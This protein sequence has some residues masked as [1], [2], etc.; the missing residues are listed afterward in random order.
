MS[1]GKAKFDPQKHH[2]RSI[3]LR[4]YDYSSGGA[5]YITIVTQGRECLFGEI[6]AREIHL[7]EYGEVIQK[8][9]NEIPIHFP[10]VELGAFIIMPNH[11]H[12]I[13]WIHE[14]QA[15][16]YAVQQNKTI[17]GKNGTARDS[18]G[19]IIQNYK[20]VTSRLAKERFGIKPLW[21]RGYYDR[22][23]RNEREL[24]AITEYIIANPANW[25]KDEENQ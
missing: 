18:L 20:S 22:V 11:I 15:K 2:R 17:P 8:W 10:N 1:L 14:Q 21:Q 24:A 9:W 3:R 4:G 19:S 25:S 12:A 7:N 5:Y 13:L 16:R 23:I 6:V